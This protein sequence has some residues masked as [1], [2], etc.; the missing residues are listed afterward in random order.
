VGV[1]RWLHRLASAALSRYAEPATR[2][3]NQQLR[4]DARQLRTENRDLGH[5]NQTL[6]TVASIRSARIGQLEHQLAAM[7]QQK[8]Q[9]K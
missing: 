1:V 5:A 8:E 7:A 9:T 4:V 2:R 6:T 3:D